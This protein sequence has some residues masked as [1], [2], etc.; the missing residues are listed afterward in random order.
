MDEELQRLEAESERIAKLRA[1]SRTPAIIRRAFLRP[2]SLT[3]RK[4]LQLEEIDSPALTGK[5]SLT[6]PTQLSTEFIPA[7]EILFPDEEIPS[8]GKLGEGIK[9]IASAVAQ[10][11]STIMSVRFPSFG[12]ETAKT[13]PATDS[14]GWVAL[15]LARFNL[16]INQILDTPIEQLFVLSAAMSIREGADATGEDYREREIE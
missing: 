10:G 7:W 12:R 16:P 6:E 14:I 1:D 2:S 15:F 3:L 9:I 4:F 8:P 13:V 5:W 11:F